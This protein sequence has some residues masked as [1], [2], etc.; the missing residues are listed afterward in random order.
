M[1]GVKRR[2]IAGELDSP[3][4]LPG[5]MING[6]IIEEDLTEGLSEDGIKPKDSLGDRRKATLVNEDSFFKWKCDMLT[7]PKNL[8]YKASRSGSRGQQEK[9]DL[10]PTRLFA[11]DPKAPLVYISRLLSHCPGNMWLIMFV[12]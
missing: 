8:F 3:Y 7:G 10:T 4:G 6:T 12:I 9:S 5:M 11:A 2:R 1:D